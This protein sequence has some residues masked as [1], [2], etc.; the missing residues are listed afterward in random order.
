VEHVVPANGSAEV[1]RLV[2]GLTGGPGAFF[3]VRLLEMLQDT[4]VETHLV[5]CGCARN[6]ILAETGCDPDDVRRLADRSYHEANQAAR[7][8]SGSFLTAGMIVAPCS[9]RS[10]GSIAN[11]YANNLIHR[12]ADVTIKEGRRL[13]L[14]VD[15]PSL[16]AIDEENL[17]R[18]NAVPAV[19]VSHPNGSGPAA[20]DATVTE[21]LAL[22]GIRRQPP[23]A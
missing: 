19:T 13:A 23:G 3:G 6:T 14:L 10:L 16:S 2:I 7:V 15:A 12:A 11:G 5:I 20:V 8:S 1:T 22:F 18:M 17:L 4:P 9:T 21:L